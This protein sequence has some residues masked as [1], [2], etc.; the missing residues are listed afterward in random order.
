MGH[1]Q[2]TEGP[3]ETI[4]VGAALAEGEINYLQSNGKKWPLI[5]RGDV[6]AHSH[7]LRGLHCKKLKF[8]LSKQNILNLKE[9][10]NDL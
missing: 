10:H 5:M 3:E 8:E 1:W 7:E 2:L 6:V 9:P 4:C